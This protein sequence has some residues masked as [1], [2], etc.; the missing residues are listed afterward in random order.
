M[1]QIDTIWQ[2]Q[3]RMA[4]ERLKICNECDRF[5][6]SL[7]KC[8]ECGCFMKAK[9]QLPMAVCPINKWGRYKEETTTE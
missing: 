1:L 5:D 6:E 7:S 2:K 9:T 8:R 3:K 4:D